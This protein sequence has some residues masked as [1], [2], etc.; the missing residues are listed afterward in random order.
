MSSPSARFLE[1]SRALFSNM[2]TK[3]VSLSTISLPLPSLVASLKSGMSDSLLAFASGAMIFLLIWSPMSGLPLSATMSLKLEPGGMVIGAY[4]T[5]SV[6][7]AN[8]LNEE[9]DEDV[10]LVLA[11]VHAA[12]ELVAA[13]PQGGIQFGFL[14][15]HSLPRQSSHCP[16]D[17]ETSKHNARASAC[18]K[19]SAR[20]IAKPRTFIRNI[21]EVTQ[22]GVAAGAWFVNRLE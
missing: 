18:P 22:R 12:T 5:P 14:E 10:V 21:V 15:R 1:K 7:V 9:Q 8:V 17:R 20:A 2:A 13:R 3:L 11:G 16:Q 4:G 19:R 6:F